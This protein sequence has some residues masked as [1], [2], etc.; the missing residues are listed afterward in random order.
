MIAGTSP[1]KFSRQIAKRSDA[2]AAV[3]IDLS[4]CIPRFAPSRLQR[5]QRIADA[6]GGTNC[7]QFHTHRISPNGTE[8]RVRNRKILQKRKCDHPFSASKRTNA[9]KKS[10]D[11][12]PTRAEGDCVNVIV[13]SPRGSRLKFDFDPKLGTFTVGR[14]LPLGMS[15]PFDWGFIPSTRG[16][17]GDPVDAMILNDVPTYPGILVRCRPIGMVELVQRESGGKPE[18]NNR[19]VLLPQWRDAHLEEASDLPGEVRAQVENFFVS[20]AKFTNK[21]VRIKGWA[22]ARKA[23]RFIDAHHRKR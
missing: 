21:Q 7:A 17:D 12:L 14:P 8:G 4:A 18:L 15:Y 10:L 11:R 3:G 1:A 5:I 9:M 6:S 16:A 19:I 20:T 2:R 13:E 22:S 23:M